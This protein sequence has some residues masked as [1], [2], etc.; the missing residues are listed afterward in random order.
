MRLEVVFN[1]D[2]EIMIQIN[3]NYHVQAL[4]YNLIA[5]EDYANFLHNEGYLAFNRSFRLFSFSKIEGDFKFDKNTM[6]LNYYNKQIKLIISSPN[7]EFIKYVSESLLLR[8]TVYL[9]NNVL[10]I[11][12]V[13]IK[14]DIEILETMQVYTLS[15][16]VVS[17]TLAFGQTVYYSP[18]DYCFSERI[19]KNL[20]KKYS[21]F[22]GKE[23]K[24]INFNVKVINKNKVRK[25]VSKYKGIIINGYL[26][27]LELTGDGELLRFAYDAA[28]GEKNSQGF[29]AIELKRRG[30][31]A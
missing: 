24:D 5:N 20:L 13:N 17:S 11:Q 3:Y 27:E 26:C 15:P 4:I 21:A 1:S 7:C 31:Y 6:M 12:S 18:L 30:I 28:L 23:V 10:K 8:N 16:I 9:H 2:D 22:K 25:K 14:P 19:K 29:G